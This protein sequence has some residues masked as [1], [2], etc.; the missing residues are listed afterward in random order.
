[1]A[2]RLSYVGELGWE[3]H[4]PMDAALP[5]LD[6][7]WEAGREF[8]MTAVGMGAFDSLRLEKGYR[9]WGGDV[10]TEH[11][12]YESGL[13]WTVKLDKVDGFIGR[14]ASAKLKAAP[15]KRKLC[16]LTLDVPHGVAL[17]NEP[18]FAN[19]QCVGHVTSA[20]YGYSVGKFIVYGYLPVEH[21][22]LGTQLEIEYFSQRFPATVS[23]D[24]QWD[25]KMVRLKA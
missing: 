1:L 17:G 4:I 19:G 23:A 11:N 2:L 14:D 7:L 6:A 13:G 18:I 5:V 8:E 15:L 25:A 20:N 21:A 16:C 12:A 9:L 10:Y 24:P 3:L 22:A